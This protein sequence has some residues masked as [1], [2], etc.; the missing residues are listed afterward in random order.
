VT[1]SLGAAAAGLAK[2]K[3]L[4]G[5]GNSPLQQKK[6]QRRGLSETP[7]AWRELTAAHLVPQPR[8]EQGLALRRRALATAAIDLSDGL[9]TDLIH[10]C[11][12]SGVA[13]TLQRELLP[14]AD[15]A[16]LEQALSGG[17]DY[18]LLFTARPETRLPRSIAG[19]PINRIG[20]IRERA[21]GEPPVMVANGGVVG[22]L[23]ARGW[24]HFSEP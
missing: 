14:V 15:G 11:E 9:S 17:E 13:A 1:G 4:A 20:R 16:S 24:E 22:P 23:E 21:A 7:A 6:S 10:L 19:V 2:L 18:E 12:E 3:E 5:Q 8:V